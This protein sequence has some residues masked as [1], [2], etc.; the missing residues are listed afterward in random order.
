[1][2]ISSA[3]TKKRDDEEE[4]D[5]PPPPDGGWG[6]MVVFGSFMIH[7]ISEFFDFFLTRLTLRKNRPFKNAFRNKEIA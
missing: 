1:M 7:V 4:S 3:T 5:L 2:T 6:W